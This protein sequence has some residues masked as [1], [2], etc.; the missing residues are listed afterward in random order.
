[1]DADQAQVDCPGC[2][3]LQAEVVALRAELARLR[4]L[5]EQKTRE[6][7]RQAAPF[8][9]SEQ[10]KADPKKPGR[11]PGDEHGE[12]VHRAAPTRIDERHDVPL[13][14]CCPHCRSRHIQE[15]RVERQYQTDI[16]RR[17]VERQFDVHVGR[18]QDC[19]LTVRNRHALQ[20][21][22]AIGAAAAQLGPDAHAAITLLNKQAGLPFGKIAALFPDLFG[23]AINRSTACRSVLQTARRCQPAYEQ[24]R[25][26]IRGSPWVVPDETGWRLGGKSAWMHVFVGPSGTYYDI[27]DRSGD[28]A[29]RLLGLDWSG[30]LIHDGWSVYD[31]FRKAF[32]QQCLGHLQRRCEGLLEMTRGMAARLPQQ[33]LTLISQAY[34]LR[35][36]WRERRLSDDD[37]A[38]A[39]LALASQLEQLASGRFKQEPNRRLADH[40]LAHA[41][42]WFWFLI[43][44]TIDATNWRAEQAIRPIVVNRK[45]W[46]GNRTAAGG[47]AQAILGSV[48]ATL[49]QLAS[50][51]ITWLTTALCHPN[52][53]LLPT[54][55]R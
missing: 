43:D 11:K 16:V 51:A 46:G 52:P 27:G 9:K 47:Q 4:V 3:R 34:E 5:V 22:E 14:G 28:V 50:D 25:R 8:R 21:S 26:D 31:R 23:I 41:M 6:G 48:L 39:G 13:P 7:K 40:I 17:P 49:R 24:I 1:M 45:V 53:L 20:T 30:T 29:E 37:Q 44:P 42:N 35:R 12:H 10:P 36:Q 38:C 54:A 2:R 18:C 55:G 15:T 32:H 19:G 33:V